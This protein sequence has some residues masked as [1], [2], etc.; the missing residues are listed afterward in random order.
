MQETTG[1]GSRVSGWGWPR[2]GAVLL[3]SVTF[4]LLGALALFVVPA[5][6][7]L[8][9]VEVTG[10]VERLGPP[11]PE[12]GD[13]GIVLEGEGYFYV[14]RAAEVEAF[15][16]E[17]LLAEVGPGD[18]LTLTEVPTWASRIGL[19]VGGGGPLAGVRRGETI[20]LDP[21]VAAATWVWQGRFAWGTLAT[22]L[23]LLLLT[24]PARRAPS[25]GGPASAL[26]GGLR[27]DRRGGSGDPPEHPADHD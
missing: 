5:P 1:R 2:R 24:W 19:E 7:P 27:L 8:T 3:L 20:Y 18:T 13:L 16:W 23:A 6:G 14:N 26:P 15:A 12:G 21:A 9:A 4:V 22:G 10:R 11:N 25:P 17:R